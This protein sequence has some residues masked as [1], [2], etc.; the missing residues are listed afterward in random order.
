MPKK[1]VK[2]KIKNNFFA[3]KK[4]CNSFNQKKLELKFKYYLIPNNNGSGER[5]LK[6]PAHLKNDYKREY[7]VCVE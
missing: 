6:K 5:G 4:Y 3:P 7:L 2:K 1:S